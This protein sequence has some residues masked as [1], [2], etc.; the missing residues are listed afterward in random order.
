MKLKFYAILIGNW[1]NWLSEVDG[2]QLI[3]ELFSENN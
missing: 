2:F 3:T 1:N